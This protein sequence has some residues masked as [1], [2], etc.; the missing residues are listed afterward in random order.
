MG[1]FQEMRNA[2]MFRSLILGLSLNLVACAVPSEFTLLA[3]AGKLNSTVIDEASGLAESPSNPHFLWI[4]N[5]SG[6]TAEIHLVQTDGTDRGK[7]S[8]KGVRNIDW[9]DLASFVLDGKPYLLVADTGDNDSRRDS[10]TLYIV[11]EP[12]LP[13]AGKSL[14]V[15]CAPAWQIRFRYEGGPR[16]CESVAVDAKNDKI[17]LLSKRTKPPEVYELPLRPTGKRG[18]LTTKPLGTTLVK[19]EGMGIIPFFDQPTGLDISAD[20]SMAAVV[21]YA[22]VFLFPRETSETWAEA[23]AK[24]PAEL[25]AHKLPQAESVAFARDGKSLRVVSEG[26]ASPIRI[27]QTMADDSPAEKAE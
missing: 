27:Y 5:D 3:P 6:G 26:A 23:F 19:G 4:V 25:G 18:I 11:P 9:E 13:A 12:E 2:I 16:D 10:C 7:L 14:D 20:A 15:T 21:T 1:G 8:V 24:K 22:G 17:V